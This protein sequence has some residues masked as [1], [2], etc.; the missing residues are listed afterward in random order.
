MPIGD[1][2]AALH[3]VDGELR[4]HW[5]VSKLPQVAAWM[6]FSAWAADGGSPYYNLGLEP[7]IGAQDS[8]AEAVIDHN[9]FATVPSH[10]LKTWRLEIELI[11]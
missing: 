2:W 3:A 1:G 4:M 6:N 5:D 9:L 10:E 11:A 7:C 8:L